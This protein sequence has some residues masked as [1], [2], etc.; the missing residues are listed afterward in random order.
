MS[1]YLVSNK[2]IDRILTRIQFNRR[3][4][5]V[6]DQNTGKAER[7]E[8]SSDELSEIGR[9]MLKLNERNFFGCYPKESNNISNLYKF[10]SVSCTK[11]QFYKSLQCF[12]YQC[13]DVKEVIE[14]DLFKKLEKIQ[15]DIAIEI[16]SNLREYNDAEWE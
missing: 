13:S 7:D 11:M 6:M 1:C 2:T 5:W 12:L 3:S 8:I 16:I 14:T 9:E 15:H 4:I 10:N